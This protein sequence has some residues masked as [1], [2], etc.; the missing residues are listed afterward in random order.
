MKEGLVSIIIPVHN[1]EKYIKEC[2]ESA[3]N[4]TYPDIEIIAVYDNYPDNSLK[5]LKKFSNRITIFTTKICN[6][7]SARNKGI[8]Q[9]KGE[10]IKFLDSDDV[11]YPNAVK[12]LVSVGK[13]LKNKKNTILYS[14]YEKINSMGRTIQKISEKN[15]NNLDQFTFNSKLL[16]FDFLGYLSSSLIHQSTVKSYGMFNEKFNYN[17]D[18]EL[19][20]RYCIL[21]NCRLHLVPKLL[22]KYR[23][24][25]ESLT[26]IRKNTIPNAKRSKTS[27]NTKE[28]I[29]RRLDPSLREKYGIA[30]RKYKE[31]QAL[32][33]NELE[34]TTHSLLQNQKKIKELSGLD[35]TS[36]K[37]LIR[38]SAN[39]LFNTFTQRQKINTQLIKEN[40]DLRKRIRELRKRLQEFSR[41]SFTD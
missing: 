7:S 29:V 13:N 21:N 28:Y 31:E 20:L 11:L 25:P 37:T 32:V 17:E 30:V 26:A 3:I 39:F 18:W 14:N 23:K 15:F 16:F 8:E 2:I 36:K 5:I 41:F 27:E 34:K 1:S 19:W 22:V 24:H 4:Q 12:E 33:V 6:A 35:V 38:T 9:S 10:W 40:K